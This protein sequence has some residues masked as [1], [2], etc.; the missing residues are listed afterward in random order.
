MTKRRNYRGIFILGIDPQITDVACIIKPYM[1]PILTTIGGAIDTITIDDVPTLLDLAGTPQI[2]S[3]LLGEIARAPMDALPC[4][5][6]KGLQ[7]TP[8]LSVFQTPPSADPK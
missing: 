2:T 6:N 4:C 8:A 1:L 7:V 3:G 5:S